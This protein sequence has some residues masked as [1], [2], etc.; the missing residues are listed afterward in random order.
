V[1]IALQL[2]WREGR[3]DR[4][5]DAMSKLLKTEDPSI[6]LLC[7]REGLITQVLHAGL[8]LAEPLVGADLSTVLK[9]GRIDKGRK[10][11]KAIQAKRGVDGWQMDVLAKGGVCRLYFAGFQAG[12]QLAVVGVPNP[13]P[14]AVTCF[15]RE[16][17]AGRNSGDV[18]EIAVRALLNEKGE[19]QRDLDYRRL[20]RLNNELVSEQR[21]LINRNLELARRMEANALLLR[22]ATHD[23]RQPV[24][25]ILVNSELL[26]EEALNTM[27]AESLEFVNSIHE[28]TEFMLR[29]LDDVV[30]FSADDAA[31][32]QLVESA[33]LMQIIRQSL[34][35]SGPLAE[36]K[37]AK[38]VL[39][40]KG[41]APTVKADAP[42]LA[43]V[44]HSLIEYALHHSRGSA[45]IE[46]QVAQRNKTAL[47]SVL[48]E[49]PGIP[50]DEISDVFTP[51]QKNR[52]RAVAGEHNTGLGLAIAKRIVEWHGGRIEMKAGD[53]VSAAFYVS[54]PSTTELPQTRSS[55]ILQPSKS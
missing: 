20:T 38:L 17:L 27:G 39:R 41:A 44:F 25:A 13:I 7:S 34:L 2:I 46:V 23:L 10:F 21:D 45:E 12:N 6:A 29:L 35:L 8:G 26:L 32:L 47:V 15:L 24:G 49:G 5:L 33:S 52:T 43:K 42:R 30:D 1:R 31:A 37:Q 16:L 53:G 55:N 40:H 18:A 28:S 54:L 48:A 14:V 11:L 51:F 9:P 22:A 4:G 19:Q 50:L 3:D 36:R